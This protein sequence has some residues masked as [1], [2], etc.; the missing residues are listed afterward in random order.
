MDVDAKGNVDCLLFESFADATVDG[1]THCEDLGKGYCTPGQTPCRVEGSD[2]PPLSLDE[3]ASQLELPVMSIDAAGGATESQRAAYV[4]NGNVY[5]DGAD[6]KTHLV[7][8]LMQLAGGRVDEAQTEAC[9]HDPKFTIAPGTGGG[10]CYSN[11]A[12]VV[13]NACLAQ[14]ASGTIRF[15]GDVDPAPGAELYTYCVK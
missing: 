2:Y 7:C 13:G 14:G 1:K 10:F 4:A 6:G 3:A 8:E 5:V 9:E 12:A 15:A 11:D